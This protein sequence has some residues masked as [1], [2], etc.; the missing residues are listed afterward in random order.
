ML[1]PGCP[2][3]SIII[4]YI[5]KFGFTDAKKLILVVNEQYNK[6]YTY[7]TIYNKL[8]S[9]L[10]ENILIKHGFNYFL[11][12]K[13]LEYLDQF[14]QDTHKKIEKFHNI[15]NHLINIEQ[16]G[17]IRH[18]FY[19][20]YDSYSFSYDLLTALFAKLQNINK[21]HEYTS[22]NPEYFMPKRKTFLSKLVDY[23]HIEERHEYMYGINNV[24]KMIYNATKNTHYSFDFTKIKDIHGKN[25][26][27]IICDD[28]IAS[29][30]FEARS[31]KKYISFFN[32]QQWDKEPSLE[33]LRYYKHSYFPNELVVEQNKPKA[34]K[35]R[36]LMQNI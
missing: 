6:N 27:Y 17:K 13:Y 10:E 30:I 25:T 11:N 14:C 3:K 36:V 26:S 5:A 34:D 20:L 33:F 19:T 12:I 32:S 2:V 4:E 8:K 29:F 15:R 9:L 31:F 1:Y 18:K 16:R 28:Y 24:T 23:Y 7:Q 22:Y 35:L 21:Y